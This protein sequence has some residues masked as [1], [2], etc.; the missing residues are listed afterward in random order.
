MELSLPLSVHLLK[1][2]DIFQVLIDSASPDGGQLTVGASIL[3][4]GVLKLSAPGK[5]AIELVAEKVLHLGLSHPDKY[6][7]G[8]QRLSVESSRRFP[9]FRARTTTV[10]AINTDHVLASDFPSIFFHPRSSQRRLCSHPL[11]C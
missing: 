8:R 5:G 2:S 6:P 9:H 11:S 4:E 3:V 10:L 7:F 1:G